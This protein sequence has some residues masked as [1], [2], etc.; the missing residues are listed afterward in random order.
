VNRI[1]DNLHHSG[2]NEEVVKALV[3]CDAEFILIGGLAVSWYCSSRQADDMDILVN[4]TEE[5]SPKVSNALCSLS[6]PINGFEKDSFSKDGVQASI[7]QHYYADI[8]TPAKG[9]LTYEEIMI[10]SVIGN[11]FNIPINIPSIENLIKLKEST[12]ASEEKEISKHQE[13]LRLLK[14]VLR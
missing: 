5:N 10:G 3:K 1:G 8:I 13:D 6:V 7:K 9:G 12:V 4:P 2:S 14:N 11:I